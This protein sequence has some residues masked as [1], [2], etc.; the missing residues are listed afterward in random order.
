MNPK[1]TIDRTET[2]FLVT[3]A[4]GNVLSDFLSDRDIAGVRPATLTFYRNEL[5]PFAN[6]I[7]EAGAKEL[8]DITPDLL[9]AYF[10]NL[11]ERRTRNGIHKNYT[12]VKT[13]LLWAWE[14][15]D[16]PGTCP[17]K[18]IKIAGPELHPQP[19]IELDNFSKLLDA[20]QGDNAKRD[21][22]ILHFLLDTG[23]RRQE[24][25]RLRLSSL[26]QGGSVYLD[27]EVTKTGEARK[28]FLTRETQKA[29][30]VYLGT[31]G[32][33]DTNS[34]L[35]A[36]DE[37]ETFSPTGMRQ[38]IRRRCDDAGITEQGMHAFR[39]GFALESRRAGADLLSVSR[40][41]GHKNV[42]TTKRYL[43]E[44]DED[45]HETHE[46]TSPIHQLKNRKRS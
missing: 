8:A 35:F 23:I 24:L 25:C 27:P 22:A 45:L 37:G 39:R 28:V 26:R 13:W 14:E 12:T 6:W 43:P 42:E 36:T 5:K 10:L 17:I 18:K 32:E 41:L 4:I 11:R 20:C 21:L 2:I 40:L 9:R 29:L 3:T 44:S 30:K 38:V 46:R 7:G 33:M 19:A 1:A 31:R 15:Y 34:P 16:Q